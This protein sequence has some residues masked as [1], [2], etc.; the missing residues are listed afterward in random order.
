MPLVSPIV[1]KSYKS[2][3]QTRSVVLSSFR[4]WLRAAPVIVEAYNLDLST[5]KIRQRIRFEYEKNRQQ[6]DVRIVN[7][8][9]FKGRTEYEETINM[10]K[11][12]T[13][14]MRYFEPLEDAKPV[15]FLQGFY[16]SRPN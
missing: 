4:D 6:G 3:E 11:Q 9:L 1:T 7:L 10:W 8:L 2:L 5:F 16:N 13:H 12:K 14:V 15:E